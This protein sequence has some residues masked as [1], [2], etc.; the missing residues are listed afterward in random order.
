[1][2]L[3]VRGRGGG[4]LVGA[5]AVL[6]VVAGMPRYAVVGWDLLDV[7]RGCFFVRVV[8]GG[9]GCSRG[10]RWRHGLVSLDCSFD[11]MYYEDPER[12]GDSWLVPE[13]LVRS[14]FVQNYLG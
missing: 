12:C 9:W 14:I 2:G 3:G 1:M 13:L 4:V 6:L 5:E 8:G 7:G 10:A 11:L